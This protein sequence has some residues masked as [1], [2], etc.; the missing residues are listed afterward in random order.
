MAPS[1]VSRF[2]YCFEAYTHSSV[3][4]SDSRVCYIF[5]HCS[6]STLIIWRLIGRQ[7]C[8]S[9]GHIPPLL[10]QKANKNLSF[11]GNEHKAAY[12]LILMTET[13]WETFNTILQTATWGSSECFGLPLIQLMQVFCVCR[14]K[15]V[16]NF[17]CLLLIQTPK[18]EKLK[19]NP[20]F[21]G[22][23]FHFK[24]ECECVRV[25]TDRTLGARVLHWRWSA[26]HQPA[27]ICL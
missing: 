13:L 25:N 9:R 7:S 22:T 6:S 24:E 10:H 8:P 23:E 20:G 16:Q 21:K 3:K 26:L 17:H 15:E 12:D 11:E 19:I 14:L 5:S 1:G 27:V 18:C 2:L 4:F